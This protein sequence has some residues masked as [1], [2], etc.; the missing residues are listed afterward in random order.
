MGIIISLYKKEFISRYDKDGLIPYYSYL[1]FKDIHFVEET[2]KNTRGNEIHFYRYYYDNCRNDKIVFFCPGIGPGHTA[3]LSEINEFAK[4][5]FLVYTIDYTGCDKSSG[6]NLVS[7]YEPTRDI[8][9]LLNKIN[10]KGEVIIVG[11]SLGAFSALNLLRIRNDIKTGVIISPFI[12]FSLLLEQVI[13]YKFVR[14][15]IIKYE[16]KT[17]AEYIGDNFDFLKTTNKNVLFI[18]SE[19]D[20]V[21]HYDNSTKI[22]KELNNPNLQ[23]IVKTDR[24]HNP[25]YTLEAVIYMRESFG[26]YNRLVKNKELKTFEEKKAFLQGKSITKMTEQDQEVIDKIVDFIK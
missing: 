12:S 22:A 11:H 21:V 16:N 18:H 20:A 13:K 1:D 6:K 23:F 17:N 15:S 5:G 10:I 9:E 7:I 2:F 24:G 19:D 14:N 25:N 26:E 3:Y 8:N 4:R